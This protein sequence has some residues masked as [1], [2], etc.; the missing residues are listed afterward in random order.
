MPKALRDKK[1]T[2]IWSSFCVNYLLLV[3]LVMGP[4]LKLINVPSETSLIKLVFLYKWVSVAK[5]ILVMGESP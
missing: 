1:F 3:L 5:S 4:T 2:N